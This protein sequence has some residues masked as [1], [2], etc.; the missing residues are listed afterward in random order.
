MGEGG[1]NNNNQYA[2]QSADQPKMPAKNTG[3]PRHR[4]RANRQ[5]EGRSAGIA[6][7]QGSDNRDAGAIRKKA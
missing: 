3:L 2:E 4:F 6:R 7:E 1:E 5:A